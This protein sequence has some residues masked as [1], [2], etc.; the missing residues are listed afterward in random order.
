MIANLIEKI[1]T[2]FNIS[3]LELTRFIKFGVVGLIGAFVDFGIFNLL[4]SLFIPIVAA[5]SQTV[6]PILGSWDTLSLWL[7]LA[8]AISFVAAI[9]SNFFWN[10][11]WT[12]PDSRSKSFR[13]QFVQFFLVNFVAVFIRVP[14][15]GATH[16]FFES[17]AQRLLPTIS[18]ETAAFLGDNISLVMAVGIVMFWNFFVN[19]YWTY[20]DVDKEKSKKNGNE[21]KF[22]FSDGGEFKA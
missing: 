10:R 12:Y 6:L 11:Y 13:R 14:I 5:D 16:G 9:V 4:R 20:A 2:R 18:S 3:P 19:R 21:E 15:V 17:T 8:S 1:A 22:E 7:A